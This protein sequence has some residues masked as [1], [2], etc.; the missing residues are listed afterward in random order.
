MCAEAGLIGD[1]DLDIIVGAGDPW[2][3]VALQLDGL[4]GSGLSNFGMSRFHITTLRGHRHAA[5]C[6][7][8]VPSS[9]SVFHGRMNLITMVVVVVDACTDD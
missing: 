5:E 4:I 6:T 8:E 1:D 2:L 7:S 9:G 3:R